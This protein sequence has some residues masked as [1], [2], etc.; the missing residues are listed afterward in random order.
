MLAMTKPQWGNVGPDFELRMQGAPETGQVIPMPLRTDV[1]PP[2]VSPGTEWA[3]AQ[4]VLHAEVPEVFGS[5]LRNLERVER[6][7]GRLVLSA[8]SRF[9]G[10]YVQTHLLSQV[11]SACQAVDDGVDE[12]VITTV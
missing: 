7:G 5:W 1:A 3:L 9:H 6:A 11:L 2:D 4:S 8:P 10:A 12:V